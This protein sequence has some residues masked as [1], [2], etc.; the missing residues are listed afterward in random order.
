MK[1]NKSPNAA[2]KIALFALALALCCG[3][4]IADQSML[5]RHAQASSDKGPG[6]GKAH[7]KVSPDLRGRK[8]SQSPVKVILQLS[9]KPS[10][11]LRQLLRRNGVR[12]GDSYKIFEGMAVELPESLVGE[13]EEFDEVAYV[14]VDRETQ[15]L[16]HVSLTTGA[17]A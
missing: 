8:S 3:I 6:Q 14:S 12:V 11:K 2:R 13:L 16:G 10:S 15:S 7:R 17:D 1:K 9:D 5:V 4:V